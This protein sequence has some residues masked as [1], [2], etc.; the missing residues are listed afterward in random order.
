ME[1]K[2]KVYSIGVDIGGT[3]M[4]AV[5]FDGE[6]VIADYLLATPKDNLN[7]FSIM[8]YALVEPLL[9]K[10]K[11]EKARV[12]G[13]GL[14][15]AGIMDDK[16][17]KIIESPNIPILN[18]VKLNSPLEKKTELPVAIDN[19]TNCFLRAEVRLGAGKKYK[20]VYGIIIG[21][22]IGGAWWLGEE[23]YQ[24]S[25]R[26]AGEPG[27]MIIDLENNIE[28]EKAYQKLTQNN[29]ANL[30]EEAFRG[31]TLAQKAYEEIG[32]CL[33]LA[34]ANIINLIDPEAIIVGGS[35]AESSELFFSKIK[36][37]MRG[38]IMHPEA[39]KIKILK[40]KL[41]QNAGAIGAALLIK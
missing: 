36:K 19:D 25:H 37:V 12:K 39:K 23:I 11:Q 10:A 15:V 8:L 18:G 7:H 31:D 3:N 34:F 33:G 9:K 5:L 13:I 1:E 35:V 32:H 38:H 17:K 2:N 21:T 22:G 41:G 26:G 28:L 30:A 14:G 6:K 24:G 20:N 4:K 27:Q 40:G 16:D 29:P